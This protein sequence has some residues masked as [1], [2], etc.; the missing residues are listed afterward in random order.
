VF[1]RQAL[2]AFQQGLTKAEVHVLVTTRSKTR[3]LNQKNEPQSPVL[4]ER[5]DQPALQP[6][7]CEITYIE[8]KPIA[9]LPQRDSGGGPTQKTNT[10][11]KV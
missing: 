10:D 3:K 6:T 5:N 4:C 11:L 9:D 2:T 1:E 7:M 8:S